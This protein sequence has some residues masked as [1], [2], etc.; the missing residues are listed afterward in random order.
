M[1]YFDQVNRIIEQ[2]NKEINEKT[3]K[4]KTLEEE[5]NQFRVDIAFCTSKDEIIQLLKKKDQSNE[6]LIKS[7]K[8]QFNLTN[9]VDK[10]LI[11]L[12]EL[13]AE[14]NRNANAVMSNAAGRAEHE[15]DR[16]FHM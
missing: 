13:Q 12:K 1:A 3:D 15:I 10:Q 5:A 4:I 8:Q 6:E 14:A 7:L 16:G 11:D 9:S 2:N